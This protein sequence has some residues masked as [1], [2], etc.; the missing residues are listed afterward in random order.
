M[1]RFPRSGIV[2]PDSIPRL[3]FTFR[4]LPVENDSSLADW[5]PPSTLRCRD[6]L[7]APRPPASPVT[8]SPSRVRPAT[9]RGRVGAVFSEP[10]HTFKSTRQPRPPPARRRAPPHFLRDHIAC[11]SSP[12]GSSSVLSF[13]SAN[14]AQSGQREVVPGSR[15]FNASSVRRISHSRQSWAGLPWVGAWGEKEDSAVFGMAVA[16][17]LD[18]FDNHVSRHTEWLPEGRP[19]ALAPSLMSALFEVRLISS[20]PLA[21]DLGKIP[22]AAMKAAF[23]MLADLR[24]LITTRQLYDVLALVGY[25][26]D[27]Y[28]VA[29]KALLSPLEPTTRTHIGFVEFCETLA[30]ILAWPPDGAKALLRHLN[31]RLG[32]PAGA[33]PASH[34]ATGPSLVTK[35]E[36]QVMAQAY[37][38][39]QKEQESAG[40]QAQRSYVNQTG[41]DAEAVSTRL[42]HHV[43]NLPFDCEGQMS[44]A[45]FR[46]VTRREPLL[47]TALEGTKRTFTEAVAYDGDLPPPF[48]K[49][50]LDI[51]HGATH[52]PLPVDG[53]AELAP[54]S[55][56]RWP[57]E[58]EAKGRKK[59][60]EKTRHRPLALDAQGDASASVGGPASPVSPTVRKEPQVT[61]LSLAVQ[62]MLQHTGLIGPFAPAA[63]A[64]DVT[65]EA[66]ATAAPEVLRVRR[67]TSVRS[68]AADDA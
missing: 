51:H 17:M 46:E 20:Q 31:K 9:H 30:A 66:G 54:P 60:K 13:R 33:G 8:P 49:A 52:E 11:A 22:P 23:L 53:S 37:A 68:R 64:I 19:P 10:V 63:S 38:A 7:G 16:A 35:G 18:A 61:Q 39:A 5:T 62:R 4:S 27:E 50:V 25:G 58:D 41:S 26:G 2:P 29:A 44:L 42:A 12:G 48:K 47:S 14:S 28:R 21:I 36:L 56:L 55:Q 67:R 65:W 40:Q 32:R 24:G 15:P 43:R 1:G 57:E 34:R 59:Q 3:D 6:G 45:A